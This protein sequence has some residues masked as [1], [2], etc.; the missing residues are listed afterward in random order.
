MWSKNSTEALPWHQHT[1]CFY[2]PIHAAQVIL[3]SLKLNWTRLAHLLRQA[4]VHANLVNSLY[5]SIY[6]HWIHA[7]I[8]MYNHNTII[9]YTTIASLPYIYG[10][11]W[12]RCS[13][14]TLLLINRFDIRLELHEKGMLNKFKWQRNHPRH[15][16]SICI[17]KRVLLY[18]V[19]G[20]YNYI[21]PRVSIRAESCYHHL[22]DW[23]NMRIT[24]TP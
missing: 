22:F 17:I 14:E 21:I 2:I 18:F 23:F 1:R 12:L 8:C 11:L 16:I 9:L 7:C 3:W 4:Y 5:A 20:S 24:K 13:A 19:H 10:T 15:A 6:Q